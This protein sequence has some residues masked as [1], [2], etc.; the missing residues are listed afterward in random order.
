MTEYQC[1]HCEEIHH[2]NEVDDRYP[3]TDYDDEYEPDTSIDCCPECQDI[4]DGWGYL[5]DSILSMYKPSVDGYF[6]ESFSE[7]DL[8]KIF[9]KDDM[10]KWNRNEVDAPPTWYCQDCLTLHRGIS[11]DDNCELCECCDNCCECNV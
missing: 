10:V 9:T 7:D 11:R 3:L 2:H 6:M 1:K 4:Q 5:H 8:K